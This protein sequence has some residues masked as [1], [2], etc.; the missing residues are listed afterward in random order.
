MSVRFQ[1]DADLNLDI[2][3]GVIRREPRVDFQTAESVD[4]R[5]LSDPE[6]LAFAAEE[7][8]I[9]VTHDLRTMPRHFADF[10][11][12]RNSSGPRSRGYPPHRDIFHV[13]V[14]SYHDRSIPSA[15]HTLP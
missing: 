6:V 10:I 13:G 7:Q 3:T 4:L 8:R 5:R 9:L 14:V 15:S 11:Q 2:L 1:A 12:R